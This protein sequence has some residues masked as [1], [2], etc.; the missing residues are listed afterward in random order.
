VAFNIV[1][2]TRKGGLLKK[3]TIY[4]HSLEV[5][6]PRGTDDEDLFTKYLIS[7][8]EAKFPYKFKP[9]KNYIIWESEREFKEPEISEIL[10]STVRTFRTRTQGRSER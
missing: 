1:L 8:L 5:K 3:K 10:N 6:L 4:E 2:R 7:C 9:F